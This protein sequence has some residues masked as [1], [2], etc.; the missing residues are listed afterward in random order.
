ML[1]S[2]ILILMQV[3]LKSYKLHLSL[4]NDD[5]N[6]EY[7]PVS[8]LSKIGAFRLFWSVGNFEFM[9]YLWEITSCLQQFSAVTTAYGL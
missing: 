4:P 2:A 6:K 7:M 5:D 8:V 9:K 1:G 3:I